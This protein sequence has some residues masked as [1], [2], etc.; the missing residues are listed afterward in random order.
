[1]QTFIR[2]INIYLAV[3]LCFMG[4]SNEIK[5]QN[6]WRG[7]AVYRGMTPSDYQYHAGLMRT[8][9]RSDTQPIIHIAG[10]GYVVQKDTWGSFIFGE[11][12]K[13]ICK[14]NGCSMNTANKYNFVATA[15]T[16]YG[17]PYTFV[18]QIYYDLSSSNY[19]VYPSMISSIR[20]DGVVEYAYEWYAYRVGGPDNY[21]DITINAAENLNA[22]AGNNITPKKQCTQLLTYVSSYYPD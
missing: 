4:Q 10:S 5:A 19:L 22:H 2:I 12:Y 1:M 13:G 20:C 6:D 8:N 18:N 9:T 16:L 3:F 15:E 11:N 7:Y 14:P 17:L 21:W